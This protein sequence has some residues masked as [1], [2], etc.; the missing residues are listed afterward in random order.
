MRFKIFIWGL[1]L[2]YS[3]L[4]YNN[5]LSWKKLSQPLRFIDLQHK[6]HFFKKKQF[7]R[8]AFW[9]LCWSNPRSVHGNKSYKKVESLQVYV[10]VYL[11]TSINNK[12]IFFYIFLNADG[13]DPSTCTLILVRLLSKW[14]RPHVNIHI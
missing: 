10:A 5:I 6:L 9:S 13:C 14:L 11:C 2:L 3:W 1:I 4:I 8:Q 7:F 12:I